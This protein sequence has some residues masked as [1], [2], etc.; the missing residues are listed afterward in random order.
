MKVGKNVRPTSERNLF[1]SNITAELHCKNGVRSM[2]YV[3]KNAPLSTSYKKSKKAETL[4]FLSGY[5]KWQRLHK[6]SDW[7]LD[8]E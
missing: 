2:C 3:M 7:T 6:S 1:W 5:L 8:Q 4:H